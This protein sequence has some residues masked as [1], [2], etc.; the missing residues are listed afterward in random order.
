LRNLAHESGGAALTLKSY[1]S[2]KA[3]FSHG[4]VAIVGRCPPHP[5]FAVRLIGRKHV[6]EVDRLTA[7]NGLVIRLTGP[8]DEPC[9]L[10]SH[11]LTDLV[12]RESDGESGTAEEKREENNN[13]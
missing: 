5:E 6:L 8:L 2:E 7:L 12:R 10:H 1:H 11:H 9:P 13:S 3:S 4:N